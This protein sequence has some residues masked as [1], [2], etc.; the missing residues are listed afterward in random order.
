MNQVI[1]NYRTGQLI[2][3]DVPTPICRSGNLLVRTAYSL[4]STG[5]ERMKV[6]QARMNLV[7]KAKARP[8]KVQQVIQNVKQVGLV[9][10]YHKVCERLDALTPLGYSL[11]GVVEEVGSGIDDFSVGDHVACAGEGIAC[12]AE[13]VHVPHNLCV[14]VPDHI[15]L[16]DAAFTTVGAIAMNGVRQSGITL[17]DTVLVV[18][19]G[20]VGLLAVQILKAA[21]CFVIGVDLDKIKVDMARQCGADA[22][23]QRDDPSLEDTISHLTDGVGPDVV[24]IAAGT[25]SSDPMHLAGQVV[26]DRGKVVI[27]GMV[28]LEADWRTYYQ[29]ELSVI[30]SRSYGPG[31]YDRTYEEK[32]LDYPISYVRWTQQRNMK[33]FLRLV[34]LKQVLPGRLKPKVYPQAEAS[35]AYEHVLTPSHDHVGGILFEYPCNISLQRKVTMSRLS[36]SKSHTNGVNVGIIGAGNFT[37]ATLIPALK[38]IKHAHLKA[39]CSAGGLRAKSAAKRHGFDY[40]ASDYRE[41]LEDPTINAVVI[42]THHDTH[43]NLTAEA[44]RASKHVFVEKPLALTREQL[45]KVI[46][47]Q[48]ASGHIVMPGFN[49]RFS[50]LSIALRDCFAERSSPIEIIC[51]VNAGPIGNDSWYKDADEG[52]W[53]IISEGCHFIDLIQFI[54]GCKPIGISAEMIGGTIPGQQ[55]DNC[56]ATLKLQDGSLASL[57]YVANGD[58]FFEKERIEVFGQGKAAV[59]ENFRRA[60]LYMGEVAIRSIRASGKGHREE[61][62]AFIEAVHTGSDSPIPFMDSVSTTTTCLACVTSMTG[63]TCTREEIQDPYTTSSD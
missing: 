36:G 62:A 17:G 49:R 28:K 48:L 5:T 43:A 13:F 9:E 54:A 50:P 14:H 33:E 35:T 27:V 58:P 24:Y 23:I 38:R 29:K 3:E 2:L 32:G 55:N 63:G 44:L 18:G 21:G 41:L 56:M 6:S 42:A 40:C 8:D 10:T 47:A 51:R 37:T 46:E 22:A 30:M 12:H 39:I 1:Q 20:L 45:D 4:V 34:G 26:R 25:D 15:D 31:R 53:R 7:Q 16:K 57:I 59:I 19:L 52:G 61:M 60:R 11:A